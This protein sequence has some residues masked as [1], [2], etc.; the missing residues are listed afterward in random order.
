MIYDVDVSWVL[1]MFLCAWEAAPPRARLAGS[2]RPL[3][4]DHS[5]AS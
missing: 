2:L 1:Q 5:I 4:C 3:F